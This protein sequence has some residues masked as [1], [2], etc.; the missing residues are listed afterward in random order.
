MSVGMTE[1]ILLEGKKV[2][3]K[4]RGE[5]LAEVEKLKRSRGQSP[6]LASILVG[7]DPAAESYL[8]SQE[9][10]AGSLGIGFQ[11]CRLP[12]EAAEK[13]LTDLVEKLSSRGS[14]VHG[15]IVQMP[16]PPH[17]DVAHVY[18]KLDPRKDVEGVH[19]ATLGFLLMRKTRL[20]PSTALACL[21]LIDETGMDCRG[22]EAV[23]VGQS[24]IVGRPVQLL[25]AERRAT[26]VLCNTGTPPSNLA[27][28][29]SRADLVV[30][31]AGKPRLIKGEWIREG[32]VVID[33]GTTRVDG[34]MVGDVEFEEAKKRA[35]YI[36]PV[37]GG[38]GPLTVL[39]LM[40]NLVQAC[41]WQ[42]QTGG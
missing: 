33:I 27:A 22:K 7:T 21:T 2:G 12:Q 24:A 37:P 23:I 28:H 4:V 25:L 29:V 41:H 26:T 30:A 32:A 16:L 34:K 42:L 20:I 1:A 17:M 15:I 11:A 31:C 9:K 19:P 36:T 10:E 38:V 39:M 35:K 8:R 18:P 40:K 6:Q 13:D 3:E 5:I 14:G